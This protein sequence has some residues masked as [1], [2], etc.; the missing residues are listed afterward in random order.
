[1]KKIITLFLS[2][3]ILFSL[4]S[5][6]PSSNNAKADVITTCF[7]IYDIATHL[8][9]DDKSVTLLLKP[10]QDSHSYDPSAK[11]I[12]KI[13]SCD[14]FISI[15]GQDESWVKTL[16]EG[17][18]LKNV[19]SL[20]LI[21]SVPPLAYKEGHDENDGHDHSHAYDEH[22]W[23]S[24]KNMTTMLDTIKNELC[25]VF[26]DLKEEIDERA[27][28]YLSDLNDL[29]AELSTLV[30]NA[31]RNI[32]IFG[33]RF[34]FLHLFTDYSIEYDAAYPG[35]SEMTEPSAATI[36]SLVNKVTAEN[37]PVIFKTQLSNGRIAESISVETGA[38]I[39]ILHSL[40]TLTKDE[41]KNN[42]T[43]YS[44]MRKNIEALKSALN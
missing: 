26:P 42:E 33:D 32:V 30:A 21:D 8:L 29:D 11:D 24:P 44:I 6:V 19:R 17:N 10:G 43:Y 9:E 35:C 39:L 38:K 34:P 15:G 4:F 37:I 12:V 2:I 20:F 23:T 41:W 27:D 14:I 31:K 7:P 25:Q 22:I 16:L 40:S 5:C 3:V 28:K 18:D 13:K 36:A 1:M